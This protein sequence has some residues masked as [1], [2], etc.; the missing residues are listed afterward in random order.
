MEKTRLAVEH[1]LSSG[2]A[3]EEAVRVFLRKHLH[4]GLGVTQGQVIDTAGN[5]SKQ[6]DVIVYD[7]QTTPMLFTSEEQGHQLVPIEGVIGIVEVKSS[8]SASTLPGIIENM[9]SVKSLEKSAFHAP[10]ESEIIYNTYNMYGKEL[11]HFPVIYSLFAF[12][13]SQFENLVPAFQQL[14]DVLPASQRIDNTCLL[15]KGVIANMTLDE[16]LDAIPG[17]ETV[18]LGL[19]TEH[20]LVTWYI[21]IQ[22]LYSQ[23]GTKPINM[24]AYLGSDF[25]F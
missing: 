20:A 4:K 6:L 15:D 21:F 3:L 22:R 13:S 1:N 2:Q 23:A 16:R 25:Y 10:S 19:P 12:E 8:V 17:P 5:T 7:A 24:Q 11:R 14:N 9:K 18:S